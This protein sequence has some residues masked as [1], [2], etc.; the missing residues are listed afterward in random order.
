LH[1]GIP[2]FARYSAC[3][4]ATPRRNFALSTLVGPSSDRALNS[5]IQ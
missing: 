1:F 3:S 4:L 5:G 2:C